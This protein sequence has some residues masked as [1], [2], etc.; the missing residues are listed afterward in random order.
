MRK[1]LSKWAKENDVT[2]VTAFNWFK[3]GKLP[4]KAIQTETGTILVEVDE[5]IPLNNDP[6]KVVIYCRV[7]QSTRKNDLNYQVQRCTDWAIQ[8]GYQIEHIYK[9]FASGMN[10]N[11][12]KFWKMIDSNPNI[13][14]VEHKDRL[15]R[16]G[17]NYIEKLLNKQ[18]CIIKVINKD[19][20]DEADLIK[21]LISIIT[22]FCCRLYGLRRGHNKA[23]IIKQEITNDNN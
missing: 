6:Q 16:F 7:S 3:A 13:I 15:T 5:N 22:S 18:N 21:D 4:V 1:K 11:R 8:N 17:F 23:K 10:D 14:I 9:E 2:Y 12:N 19:N 20:E